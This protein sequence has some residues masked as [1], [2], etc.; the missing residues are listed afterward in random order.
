MTDKNTTR[1][2]NVLL[3][4][5]FALWI[6]ALSALVFVTWRWLSGWF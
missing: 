4:G 1:I 6:A 2:W 5:M 3:A